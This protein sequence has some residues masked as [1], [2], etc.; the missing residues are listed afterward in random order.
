MYR[1]WTRQSIEEIAREVYREMNGGGSNTATT[2]NQSR[3]LTRSVQNETV[4][5]QR[6]DSEGMDETIN[7]GSN[8]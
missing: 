2:S 7:Q 3:A 8:T 1:A 4:N 6:L 5:V